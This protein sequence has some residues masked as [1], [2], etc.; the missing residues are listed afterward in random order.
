ME[1]RAYWYVKRFFDIIISLILII[2]T[3]PIILLVLLITLI[4]IGTPLI[5]IRIP[6][7]GRN[8][9]PFYM[10]KIRTRVY[11]KDF[12]SSYTKISKI[13]DKL[14]LNELVQ[15]FNVLKGDMSIVGPRPFIKDEK[16]PEGKISDKRY[17]VRPGITGL[18]TVN[19]GIYLSHK[20]KLEY[21]EIYYD[22][23]GFSQDLKIL[24]K[25]PLAFI[26]QIK[27]R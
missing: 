10:Y 4:N 24:F 6:R 22:N 17:L 14:G 13:I 2:L 20:K 26:K 27:D 15:L 23:F 16:L 18:A 8:K 25:T 11:D 5:D 7:L 12:N 3:L 9:K 1:K 21:D 19:G